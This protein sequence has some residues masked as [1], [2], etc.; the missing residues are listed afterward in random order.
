[1]PLSVGARLPW[2]FHEKFKCQEWV[3]LL[4]LTVGNIAQIACFPYLIAPGFV[5]ACD[6]SL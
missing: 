6:L 4:L 3:R 2:N 1:M 5:I